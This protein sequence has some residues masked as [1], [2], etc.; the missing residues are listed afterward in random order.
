MS[1]KAI[2]D[3]HL[4]VRV[5]LSVLLEVSSN[6][7]DE[8]LIFDVCESDQF[9]FLG[10]DIKGLECRNKTIT[11]LVDF[12]KSFDSFFDSQSFLNHPLEVFYVF[13]QE[14]NVVLV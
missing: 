12:R 7:V 4:A 6:F 1:C 8:F 3:E 2:E 5:G 9:F 13:L 10:S 14:I 11:V